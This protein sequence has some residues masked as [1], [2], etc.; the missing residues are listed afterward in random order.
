MLCNVADKRQPASTI[1]IACTYTTMPNQDHQMNGPKLSVMSSLPP[2]S[3]VQLV[4]SGCTRNFSQTS[5][6]DFL[7]LS[8]LA[9]PVFYENLGTHFLLPQFFMK[10]WAHIFFSPSFL[11]KHGHTSLSRYR[12]C[13]TAFES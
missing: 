11:S 7:G 4:Q 12:L 3:A 5:L 2:E 13:C 9:S 10:T 6:A 1:Q 8:G